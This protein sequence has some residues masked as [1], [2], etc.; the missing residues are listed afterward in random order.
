MSCEDFLFGVD[1]GVGAGVRFR[2]TGPLTL[3]VNEQKEH[4]V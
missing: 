2:V 3:G 4:F 1:G